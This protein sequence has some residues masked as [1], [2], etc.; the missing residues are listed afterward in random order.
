MSYNED[1]SIAID[2]QIARII[3]TLNARRQRKR[4]Q[5]GVTALQK[6]EFKGCHADIQNDNEKERKRSRNQW[7]SVIKMKNYALLQLSPSSSTVY[8]DRNGCI[9]AFVV[10]CKGQW[11]QLD[12]LVRKWQKRG[13]NE[14]ELSFSTVA[15]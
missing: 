7:S 6:G 15:L 2:M 1:W 8:T 3:S 13:A 5:G 11:G 4:H 12:S 9:C 10:S 14:M